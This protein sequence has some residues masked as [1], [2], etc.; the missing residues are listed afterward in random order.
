MEKEYLKNIE[1]LNLEIIELK[2]SKEYVLGRKILTI[3]KLLKQF[4]FKEV[5]NEITISKKI[6]KYNFHD[7]QKNNYVIPKLEN[8]R[9]PK[10]VV[11]TCVTGNYDN[12]LE[13]FVKVNNIDFVLF[14]DIK[15]NNKLK[16]WN[17]MEIPYKLEKYDNIYKN[18]YIKMHPNDFFSEYDYSI[19]I[20]GNV[21]VMSDL[22]DLVYSVNDKTGISMHRHKSR[23]CIYNEIEVCK[24]RKKGNYKELKNQVEKYRNE[25]FPKEF[26]MLEA[27]VIVTDLK[28]N[29]A[30]KIFEDWWNEFCLI[31]SMR[32]QISLHYIIWKNKLTINDFG[33][34]GYNLYRNPKFRVST[35][36]EL[37]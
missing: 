35:H 14:T 24:I 37:N 3:K 33:C 20:D 27:T 36:K 17:T 10:I 12:V 1:K 23:N 13:P 22:T 16:Y 28:N 25:G 19:Y 31:P 2:K 11:Y 18:R 7:E 8:E 26:G 32:D 29:K 15:E 34:L 9:K 5:I 21:Q 6:K 30:K 4:K